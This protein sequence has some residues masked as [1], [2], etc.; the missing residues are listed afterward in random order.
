MIIIKIQLS[1][2]NI[3]EMGSRLSKT[4]LAFVLLQ[5]ESFPSWEHVKHQKPIGDKEVELLTSN[6]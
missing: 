1:P 2:L 5:T 4:V 6:S 3:P